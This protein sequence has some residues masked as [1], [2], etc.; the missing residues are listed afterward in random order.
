MQIPYYLLFSVLIGV[1]ACTSRIEI[2]NGTISNDS[3]IDIKLIIDTTRYTVDGIERINPPVAKLISIYSQQ[4]D[5]YLKFASKITLPMELMEVVAPANYKI[6]ANRKARITLNGISM[7]SSY[8]TKTPTLGDVNI[9]ENCAYQSQNNGTQL[10]RP[11]DSIHRVYLQNTPVEAAWNNISWGV[12]KMDGKWIWNDTNLVKNEGFQALM[13][14]TYW[15]S[16]AFAQQDNP[17]DN[18]SYN[19]RVWTFVKCTENK[20][21]QPMDMAILDTENLLGANKLKSKEWMNVK[22]LDV[23]LR[24]PARCDQLSFAS[25]FTVSIPLISTIIVDDPLP[26]EATPTIENEDSSLD[27]ILYFDRT[28][29][30]I[31]IASSVA[32]ISVIVV[33]SI[34]ISRKR[35]K[36]LMLQQLNDNKWLEKPGGPSFYDISVDHTVYTNRTLDVI[37]LDGNKDFDP[38]VDDFDRRNT[39]E[40]RRKRRDGNPM[41]SDKYNKMGSHDENG[42]YG[43]ELRCVVNTFEQPVGCIYDRVPKKRVS[44]DL[45]DKSTRIETQK[46]NNLI[47]STTIEDE[48]GVRVIIHDEDK[49]K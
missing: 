33:L 24:P 20:E 21:E 32:V 11:C 44:E 46:G 13:N 45:L 43:I 18:P 10:D 3:T 23:A 40:L 48:E 26:D 7:D 12:E 25:A 31:A 35:R 47:L 2:I 28:V 30:R 4:S 8:Y 42:E 36:K 38:T 6:D 41:P 34:I 17:L 15:I 29:V 1:S 22:D 37:P 27:F 16:F 14:E 49:V 9:Y 19:P 39:D 5:K